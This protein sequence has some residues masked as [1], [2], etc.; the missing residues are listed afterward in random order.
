M[1]ELIKVERRVVGQEEINAVDARELWIFLES[2]QQFGNW[3]NN[4]IE[5]Y[6]F[7]EGVDFISFNNSIKA[8]NTYINTKEYTISIDMAKELSMV[9]KTTKGKDARKYFIQ[10]EKDLKDIQRIDVSGSIPI[11]ET[12][13]FSMKRVM[14]DLGIPEQFIA[15]EVIEHIYKLGGPDLRGIIKELPCFKKQ[16][17][18]IM[19]EPTELGKVF[20]MS[21]SR[22]NKTLKKLGLQ[23]KQG[24]QWIPTHKGD[25]LCEINQW[26]TPYKSG[27]NYK[28]NLNKVKEL[29]K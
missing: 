20:E 5:E 10:C 14:N 19:L 1:N 24:E 15:P 13:A 8:E 28:W 23:S 9:E 27:F 2:G 11:W 25:W 12:A 21:A 17:M 3:M 4:R 18:P 22:M 29:M 6:K 7:I 26:E 16:K